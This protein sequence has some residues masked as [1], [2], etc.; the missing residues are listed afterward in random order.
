M[1]IGTIVAMVHDII[2]SVGV[3]SV[4]QFEVTP[5]TVIAFLTILGYSIYD[6]IVVF[7]KVKENENKVSVNNRMTYSDM[8]SLSMNQVLIRSLNT[9]VVAIIPVLSI[10]VVGAQILGAVTLEEFGLA[11]FVGMVVGAY[12]SIFVAAPVATM[13]RERG[14]RY[15]SIRER[16]EATRTSASPS[17]V[18]GAP[19]PPAT[20]DPATTRS[21]RPRPPAGTP[22]TTAIPPRPRKKSKGKRR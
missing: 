18:S 19:E 20:P 8:V 15:R 2:I 10:L 21:E 16:I 6:T 14:H 7:D 9:T 12:S 17:V 3:Y 4:F 13:I 11:L 5:G 22:I 1:A